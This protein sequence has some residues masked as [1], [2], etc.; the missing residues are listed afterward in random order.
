MYRII[1]LKIPKDMASVSLP[2]EIME[3]V[4]G[5]KMIDNVNTE[6]FTPVYQKIIR[7]FAGDYSLE[8]SATQ[9]NKQG[10]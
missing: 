4:S 10:T 1:M 7:P 2:A 8:P 6:K 3:G 5:N 9:C